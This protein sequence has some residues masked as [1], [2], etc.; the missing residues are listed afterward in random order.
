VGAGIDAGGVAVDKVDLLSMVGGWG[1]RLGAKGDF[2]SS[3]PISKQA[4]KSTTFSFKI[5]RINSINA[6]VKY[7]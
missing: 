1:S 6:V 7:V 5:F 4:Y 3:L 2:N